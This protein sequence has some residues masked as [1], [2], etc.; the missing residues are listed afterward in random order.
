MSRSIEITIDPLGNSKVEA[1]G[2]KGVG[3][4]DATKAIEV[5]LTGPGGAVTRQFKPERNMSGTPVTKKQEQR[6]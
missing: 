1:V 4:E 3:C 2:F 6:W 5:A